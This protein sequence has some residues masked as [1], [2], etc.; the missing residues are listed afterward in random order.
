MTATHPSKSAHIRR[1]L[2]HPV[3]DADGHFREATPILLDYVNAVGGAD[4]RDRYERHVTSIF[5]STPVSDEDRR[6]A[7]TPTSAWWMSPASNTYDLATAALPGLL[8]ER[9]DEMGIDFSILY[10]SE[11]V[12]MPSIEDPELRIIACRAFNTYAAELF[13]DF[14]DRLTPAAIIP[15]HTPQEGIAELEHAVNELGLKVAMVNGSVRRPIPKFERE[16]PALNGRITWLDTFGIDS[17]HDYDPFWAK[18]QE[19][20][21]AVTSHQARGPIRGAPSRVTCTTR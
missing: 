10:P 9:L 16:F 2:G 8:Y 4:A 3:I 19:L 12:S 13:R 14:S 6:D 17:Q 15:M 1:Q 20:G 11:G 7:R 5:R 21:I 18:C